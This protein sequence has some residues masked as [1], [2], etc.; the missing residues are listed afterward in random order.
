MTHQ[1]SIACVVLAAGRSKRFGRGNKLLAEIEGQ[2]LIRK[3]VSGVLDSK[4]S[5]VCIVLQ[6]ACH[7]IQDALHGLQHTAVPN[8]SFKNGIGSSIA[9]GIRSLPGN[10]DGAFVLPGDMPWID[11][12][13]IDPMIALFEEHGGK[14]LVV[15]MTAKSQQRNPVLW[16][17]EYFN[18]LSN[19][20]ADQGAKSLIPS[21]PGLRIDY[22]VENSTYFDDIDELEDLDRHRPP[23]PNPNDT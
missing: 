9:A 7:R 21:A 17:K 19:L 22:R 14:H 1:L 18:Q 23:H 16:P 2:P 10:I 5:H 4:C 15:P 8:S 12:T 11:K 20:N 13:L 6:P 3:T